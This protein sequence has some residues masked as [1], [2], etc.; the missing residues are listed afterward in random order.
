MDLMV[1]TALH[2]SSIT[3]HLAHR[4]AKKKEQATTA[5]LKTGKR[6]PIATGSED[7]QISA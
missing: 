3:V 1:V 4:R 5:L 6:A 7:N 2:I